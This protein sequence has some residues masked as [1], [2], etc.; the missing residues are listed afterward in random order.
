MGDIG[1]GMNKTGIRYC[2]QYMADTLCLIRFTIHSI[3][4]VCISQLQRTFSC[5]VV[6]HAL[7]TEAQY[8]VYCR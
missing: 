1:F 2:K 3:L 5:C 4:S 7:V 6:G 8:S